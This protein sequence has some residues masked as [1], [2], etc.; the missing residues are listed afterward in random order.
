MFVCAF[1]T[2]SANLFSSFNA[3]SAKTLYIKTLSFVNKRFFERSFIMQGKVIA[4]FVLGLAGL[5]LSFIGGWFSIIALP[6][7]IVGLI[8]SI[9]GGKEF[10]AAGQ[11]NGLATAGLVIGIIAVAV[12]AIFFFTCGICVLCVADELSDLE[13]ELSDLANALSSAY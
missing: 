5:V 4:G 9:V 11:P 1:Y 12:S 7:A 13:K 3:L 8:L 2:L 6:M 10:K